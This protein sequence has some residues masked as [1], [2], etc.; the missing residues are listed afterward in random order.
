MGWIVFLVAGYLLLCFGL[1]KV[2]P[3]AGLPASDAWIPGKNFGTWCELIGRKRNHAWWLLFPIVN[4]F[5]YSGMA[6][7]LVRSFGHMKFWHSFLAVIGA[8]IYSIMLGNNDAKY[9]GP[10]LT[11]EKEYKAKLEEAKEKGQKG[12]LERLEKSNPYKKSAG[13]EWAES[14]IFA[15]FAAAFIRMFFI[16]MYKIP[17]PSMEGSLLVG[18][19]LCVKQSSLWHPH[20]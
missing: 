12:K 11:N 6:V 2:F 8:P 14:I 10:I 13:R 9:Q 1:S 20:T 4:F 15:V 3:K 16:E 7:D 17:T 18:D 5:T 19:F